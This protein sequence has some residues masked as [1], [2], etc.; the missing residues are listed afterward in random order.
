MTQIQL[1]IFRTSSTLITSELERSA[2]TM[3]DRWS[4]ENFFKYMREN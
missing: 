1:P 4:Q 3:C 2:G